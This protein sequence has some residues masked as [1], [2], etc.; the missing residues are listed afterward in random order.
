MRTRL[1]LKSTSMEEIYEALIE[2]IKELYPILDI[3]LEWLS[4]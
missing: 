4:D 2:I 1:H 3:I